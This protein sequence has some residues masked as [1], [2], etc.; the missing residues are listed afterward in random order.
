M[1]IYDRPLEDALDQ[2]IDILQARGLIKGS[3]RELIKELV[4]DALE[5]KFGKEGTPADLLTDPLG[6]KV[7]LQL[8]IGAQMKL[9][10]ND[11]PHIRLHFDNFSKDLLNAWVSMQSVPDEK[12]KLENTLDATL[13]LTVALTQNNAETLNETLKDA[14]TL[15]TKITLEAKQEEDLEFKELQVSLFRTL[16]G[17]SPS[18]VP[19]INYFQAG[20]SMGVAEQPGS[21]WN[22][23]NV[24]GIVAALD[25]ATQ[26]NHHYHKSAHGVFAKIG[27]A[28][29]DYSP[30][31]H[32]IGKSAQAP[33]PMDGPH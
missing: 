24:S 28:L 20:D 12:M 15:E 19:L 22:D 23:A 10:L 9:E 18:G 32:K 5:E 17:V 13:T 14:H 2:L 31:A 7:L 3:G 11:N 16:Y 26:K 27:E 33:T 6:Q 8:V 4:K 21:R 1:P 30:S 25:R 29:D